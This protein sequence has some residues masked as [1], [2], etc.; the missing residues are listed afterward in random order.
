MGVADHRAQVAALHVEAQHNDP[1]HVLATDRVGLILDA[2]IGNQ[3]QRQLGAFGRIQRVGIHQ[4]VADGL[5]I[6][7]R[8]VMQAQGEI[9]ALAALQHAGYGFAVQCGLDI[10]GDIADVDSITRRLLAID[11][12]R[13]LRHTDLLLEIHID[14]AGHG[15][16]DGLCLQAERIEGR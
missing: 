13:D 15:A 9:E 8:F 7:A 5:H 14:R 10:L 11:L 4:D 6:V 3:P 12:D 2:D 1:L 16:H